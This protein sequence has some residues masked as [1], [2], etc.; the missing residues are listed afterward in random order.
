MN[1]EKRDIILIL[2]IL[3]FMIGLLGVG[4]NVVESVGISIAIYFGIKI[5]VG[6]RKKFLDKKIGEGFCAECGEKIID[7]KCPNCDLPKK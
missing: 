4:L 1:F 3:F 7:K 2:G 6:R 5:F